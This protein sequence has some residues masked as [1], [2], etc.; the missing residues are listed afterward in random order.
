MTIT[1]KPT[2]PTLHRLESPAGNPPFALTKHGNLVG[3]LKPQ[4]VPVPKRMG[5][6]VT[7]AHW[8]GWHIPDYFYFGGHLGQCRGPRGSMAPK[9]QYPVE[10]CGQ[11]NAAEGAE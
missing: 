8:W 10:T 2:R 1:T 5:T 7:C 3:I 6:C 9:H 11:W 4:A